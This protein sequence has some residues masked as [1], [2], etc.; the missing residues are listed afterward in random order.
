MRAEAEPKQTIEQIREAAREQWLEYR[1][2]QAG[3]GM[4][5]VQEKDTEAIPGRRQGHDIVDDDFSL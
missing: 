1:E 5:V 4:N 2:Q 3:K